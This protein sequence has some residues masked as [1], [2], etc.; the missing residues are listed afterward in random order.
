MPHLLKQPL[1]DELQRMTEVGITRID[2]PTEWVSP[3]G[4]VRKKNGVLRIC[5]DPRNINE[6]LKR[7][8]FE[9]PKCEEIEAELTGTRVF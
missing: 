3:L 7:E 2:E 9:N 6:T 5:M 4:I 8:H 1:K